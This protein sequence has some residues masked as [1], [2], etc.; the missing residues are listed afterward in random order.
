MTDEQKA[1]YFTAEDFRLPLHHGVVLSFVLDAVLQQSNAKV[2]PLLAQEAELRKSLALLTEENAK[3]YEEL[4]KYYDVPRG[5]YLQDRL[6]A[7]D[8]RIA[9][10]EKALQTLFNEVKGTLSA[11]EVAIRYDHG[12]SNWSCLE[13]AIEKAREALRD[14]AGTDDGEK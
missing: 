11:H 1:P 8:K 14:R 9:E 3:L 5:E 7:A 10:L 4:G 6:E 13:M 12:N 2:A